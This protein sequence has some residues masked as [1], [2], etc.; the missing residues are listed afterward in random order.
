MKKRIFKALVL[1]LVI[2]LGFSTAFAD[3]FPGIEGGGQLIQ[4]PDGAKRPDWS[5]ISFGGWAQG[6]GGSFV[7]EWQVNYHNVSM[8]SLDKAQFHSTNITSINYFSGDSGTCNSALN[9]TAYGTLNG[10]PGYYVI[11]RFGDFGSPG[12]ADTVRIELYKVGFGKV[13]DTHTSEFQDVS[14]CVGSARTGLDAG[15]IKITLP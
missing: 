13:F 2:S 5:V 15:N 9:L 8:D 6:T 10:E 12:Y 11:L 4:A 7:G 14:S 3:G 1:L